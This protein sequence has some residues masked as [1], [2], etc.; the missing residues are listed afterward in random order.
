MS[1]KEDIG[2]VKPSTMVLAIR[3]FCLNGNGIACDRCERACPRSAITAAVGEP[4]RID[5]SACTGCGI[6]CGI[7]DAFTLASPNAE[8]V[9]SR[10]RRI[11]LSGR[12]A[13]LACH[14]QVP[15][16]DETDDSS[17]VVPC[18]AALPPEMWTLLLA[19]D[20]EIDVY[21][22]LEA[23]DTCPVA[24]PIAPVLFGRAIELAESQTR[25]QVGI[26]AKPCSPQAN[27]DNPLGSKELG[28]REAFDGIVSGITEIFDGSRNLRKSTELQKQRERRERRQTLQELDMSQS[29]LAD[30]IST[31]GNR[32][33]KTL[34]PRRRMLLETLQRR[35]ELASRIDVSVAQVDGS[36]CHPAFCKAT[37]QLACP[38]GA[39]QLNAAESRAFI[40]ARFCIGCGACIAACPAHAIS[41][42]ESDASI[43]MAIEQSDSHEER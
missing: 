25:R 36:R 38:T 6:C 41:I 31:D 33:R 17:V 3:A 35:P 15:S 7:C 4:A 1:D 32:S 8:Q 5:H 20:I 39:C 40:D 22:N 10:I 23:C 37:C 21:C 28:R 27:T 13:V 24:G 43:L 29:D 18:L 14:H 9:Q 12:H 42:E 26:S 30:S 11:A 19:Q 16:K 34:R 2:A